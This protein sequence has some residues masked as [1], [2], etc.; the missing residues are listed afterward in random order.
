MINLLTSIRWKLCL[1][2][3]LYCVSVFAQPWMHSHI[4]SDDTVNQL[5]VHV[6]EDFQRDEQ[7]HG[8]DHR[9]DS[10]RASTV[11]ENI[12]Q[13]QVQSTI[14]HLLLNS[15]SLVAC[16]PTQSY[17]R[18]VLTPFPVRTP[19]PLQ[20]DPNKIAATGT[21]TLE[22]PPRLSSIVITSLTD[23]SPPRA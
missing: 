16:Q 3:C 7:G 20:R 23:L 14:N 19:D 1:V 18:I 13:P 15:S 8:N 17:C 4:D 9:N 22:K 12:N 6:G 5:H 21:I 10:E 2:L 11:Q